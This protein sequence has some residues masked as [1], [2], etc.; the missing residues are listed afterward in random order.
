MTAYSQKSAVILLVATAFCATQATIAAV[1]PS[2]VSNNEFVSPRNP[3]I[4]VRVDPKFEYAGRVPFAIENIASGYRYIFVR[5][6]GQRL[7]QKLIQRMF[8]IQQ[9]GFLPSS[10]DT[11][12]YRITNPVKLGSSDYRHSVSFDD[13]DATIRAEPG[14]EADVT[15]K[16]LTARGYR[17]ESEMVMARFARPADS[18]HRH[19][20]IFFCFE[21]LSSYGHKLTDFPETSD[22]PAK[23]EIQ[24]Q[25]DQNCRETFRVID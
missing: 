20:I 8:I 10:T 23:Q 12:K 19:E 1:A 22:S 4:Q 14:K 16:F 21:N 3:K 13:N 2:R 5:V 15:R 9:E 11:Y 6:S 7:G 17:M 18:E 25:V 24:R